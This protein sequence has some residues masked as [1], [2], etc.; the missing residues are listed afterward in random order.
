MWYIAEWMVRKQI[1]QKNKSN[2]N[3]M[4]VSKFEFNLTASIQFLWV[5]SLDLILIFLLQ[6]L[7][8]EFAYTALSK[9]AAIRLP[10]F[11]T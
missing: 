6:I 3:K 5:L 11:A 8:T 2:N 9:T 4:P 10:S 1:S 7:E